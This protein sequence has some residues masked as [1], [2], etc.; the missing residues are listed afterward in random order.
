MPKFVHKNMESTYIEE[1]KQSISLLMNHL[2]N[3]PVGASES[4]LKLPK[5][6]Q[7]SKSDQRRDD[8]EPGL[9][10][11]DVVLNFDIE[12]VVMEVKG[13]KS[14]PPNRIVFCVM[15]LEGHNKL[16]TDQAEASRPIWDTSGDFKTHQPLPIIKVKLCMETQNILQD[17]KEVGRIVLRPDPMFTRASTWYVMEKANKNFPDELK[18]KLTVR[19]DKPGN[20]KMCGWVYCMGKT[21]WKK[22]KKRYL[23]LVQ[24]SQYTFVLCSYLEKKAEPRE[25]MTLDNYTV[26]YADT[27]PELKA[28]GGRFFFNAV[29]EGDNVSFATDEEAERQLWIQALYRATGQSHKPTPPTLI[30]NSTTQ[31]KAQGDADKARKHGMEEYIQADPSVFNHNELF[32]TLQTLT[33][34]YRLSDQFCSLGWFS[35]GQIFVLDE[36]QAR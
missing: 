13:L 28:Q 20:L 30:I 31:T 12:L 36:Y 19:I 27:D 4:K 8:P 35:P 26:D 34:E 10:K 2:D 15:E 7:N 17:M 1:L 5:R 16:Q 22:Y 9:S 11:N 23:C 6:V 25:L 14:L 33:L 32:K 29:K 21:L 18:I 3:Q 24:V